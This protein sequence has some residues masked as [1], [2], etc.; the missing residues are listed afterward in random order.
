[1]FTKTDL[2]D[3]VALDSSLSFNAMPSPSGMVRLS[4]AYFAALNE[5]IVL[6]IEGGQ[7]ARPPEG[8]IESPSGF[9]FVYLGGT[10]E[11]EDFDLSFAISND[12]PLRMF[13][14]RWYSDSQMYLRVDQ[15]DWDDYI[16][17]MGSCVSRDSFEVSKLPLSGYRARFSFATL[18]SQPVAVSTSL[19]ETN[20]SEFQRRMV[21]GDLDKSNLDLAAHSPGEFVVV[22]FIDERLPIRICGDKRFTVSPEFLA[23]SIGIE[24]RSLDVFSGDYYKYFEAGWRHFTKALKHKQIILNEVFWATALE[25][26]EPLPDQDL[27][28]KQNEKLRRLYEI[29]ASINPNPVVLRYEDHEMMAACNHQW[30]QSPFH[31]GEAF[32]RS[33]GEKLRRL[34]TRNR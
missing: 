10:G 24:G 4:G 5:R 6:G 2:D 13:F 14:R 28:D 20:P 7:L 21:R 9:Y 18:D 31:F 15:I 8:F 11:I 33:Q 1:M 32:N 22:D 19:L 29:V 25:N 16:F 3:F 12:Q 26:G 17:V 23:T 34:T 30:G 27:I